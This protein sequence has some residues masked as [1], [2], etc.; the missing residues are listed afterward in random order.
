LLCPICARELCGV[1]RDATAQ[2]AVH[3]VALPLALLAALLSFLAWTGEATARP[4]VGKDGKI[5][6]C[7][8]VKG[9]PRGAL[10]VVKSR[11][12]R[13]RR[14][15]RKVAWTVAGATGQAGPQGPHGSHGGPGASA[16]QAPL[17]SVFSEQISLLTARI[18]SLEKTLAV[19]GALCQQTAELATQVNLLRGVIGGLGLEP[20]LELIGLLE[21]P[22]LPDALELEE[23]GCSV[24]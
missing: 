16:Q 19:V 7:Y 10:R 23:F 6:A 18:D 4:L 5:Y 2:P 12:A 17:S 21:I 22:A 11:K 8:K 14:G 13:C 20:A 24:P 1:N 15:E 9:K 3:R